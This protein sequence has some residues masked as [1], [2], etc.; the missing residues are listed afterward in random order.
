MASQR[1]TVAKIGGPAADVALQRLRTWS[2]ARQRNS[3]EQWPPHVRAEVDA[4]AARVRA[5]ALTLP[6][7]YFVE[8]A[9][10]WSMGDLFS[11]WLTPTGGPAPCEVSADQYEIFAYRLP[12]GGALSAHLAAVGPRQSAEE[13]WFVSRLREA[14]GAWQELVESAV[15]VVLRHVVGPSASDEEVRASLR[16]APDWLP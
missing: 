5:H 16:T 11:A 8:W 12:D 2:A 4:F 9:D 13:G 1:I 10:L 3:P 14:V 6:V 7:V 15:L